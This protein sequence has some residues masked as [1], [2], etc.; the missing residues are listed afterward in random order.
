MSLGHPTEFTRR[1]LFSP[2]RSVRITS[3]L[4]GALVGTYLLILLG[5][6]AGFPT[7][8]V[9]DGERKTVRYIGWYFGATMLAVGLLAVVSGVG[10]LYGAATL[11]LSGLF[12][13]QLSR[14]Y[15]N[16]TRSAALRFFHTSNAYLGTL[17]VVIILG[18]G[19]L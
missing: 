13:V 17:L 11:V 6:T 16:R 19:L 1:T 12:F 7:L 8:S 10:V 15:R 18:V 3:L 2:V 5:I 14:L 4:I 9:V